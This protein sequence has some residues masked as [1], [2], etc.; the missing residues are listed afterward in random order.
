VNRFSATTESEAVVAAPREAIWAV[1]TDP[2]VL[3]ELT[4]LLER[5]ETD[6]D[7]WRWHMKSISALG[8]SIA[9]A[10]TERMSFVDGERIDYRH[11]APAGTV[12]RTGADGWYVLRDVA[13]GTELAIS[14]TLSVDLP[15]PRSASRAVEKVMLSTMARTGDRF[16]ANLL[17]HL[18]VSSKALIT[19]K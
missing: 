9:P 5:I 19:Q 7:Y 15:L 10:F 17:R 2:K 12:E 4:P 18:G 6:G 16:S 13:D 1:L 8:V 11:D 14:L 3:P